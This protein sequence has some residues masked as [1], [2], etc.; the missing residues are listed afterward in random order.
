MHFIVFSICHVP[1]LSQR[2]FIR[3]KKFL[4][5]WRQMLKESLNYAT[6]H[7]PTCFSLVNAQL[8]IYGST[9]LVNLGRFFS[10]SIHT[11]SVDILERGMSPSQGRYLH[12]EQH[13][14]RMNSHRHPCLEWNSR[15]PSVRGGGDGSD[16]RPR[17]YCD[18]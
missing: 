17:S 1:L 3:T 11:Q 14:Q 8:S 7:Q 12:T 18:R 16:L 6:T 4:S 9:A 5:S 2:M 15:D 10:F 13:K